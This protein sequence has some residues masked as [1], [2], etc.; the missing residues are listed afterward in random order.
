MASW[1]KNSVLGADR[2]A[3]LR[4]G[5]ATMLSM[6]KASGTSESVNTLRL[7]KA[8]NLS[9]ASAHVTSFDEFRKVTVHR[10]KLKHLYN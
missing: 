10:Q 2:L 3:G 9:N 1:K 5:I 6:Q 7:L 4:K 8:F